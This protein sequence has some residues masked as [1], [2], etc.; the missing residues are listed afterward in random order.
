MASELGVVFVETLHVAAS[1]AHEAFMG[2]VNF[3]V[4]LNGCNYPLRGSFILLSTSM[5][6][7][8]APCG[9]VA[10]GESLIQCIGDECDAVAE[11]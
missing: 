10:C 5:Y 4:A 8:H 11:R 7:A 2:L 3:P 6:S 9:V 1:H